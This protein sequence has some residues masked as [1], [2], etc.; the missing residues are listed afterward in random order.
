MFY[1]IFELQGDTPGIFRLFGSPVFR[2]IAALMTAM[3]VCLTLYPWFIRQ[4]Q[5]R[6]IGEVINKVGPES[7]LKKTGTPTMGGTL[8]VLS[9]L[10]SVL[11]WCDLTNPFVWL[12]SAI[13]LCYA[14]IG[15]VDDFSKLKDCKGISERAKIITQ[16]GTVGVICLIFF[17]QLAPELNY[18]LAVYL[19]FVKPESGA[20]FLPWW[21]YGIFA[22]LVIFATSTA[23]NLTD[24]LDGL[25]I[26]PVIVSAA[27]FGV[28]CYLAGAVLFGESL[29]DHL[30]LPRVEGVED[31]LE[32]F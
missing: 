20:I 1:W 29:A 28:L 9:L 31:E 26:G 25:A 22:T 21:A 11:L 8:L 6:Q 4:L 12:T 14:I 7:H 32:D 10:V 19:P 15:F 18:E 5:I 13:T 27:T 30:L 24:G 16:L 23:T 3:V 17:N 2:I